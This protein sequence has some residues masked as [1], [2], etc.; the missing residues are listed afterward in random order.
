MYYFTKEEIAMKKRDAEAPVMLGYADVFAYIIVILV[1]FLLLFSGN[2]RTEPKK[3]L[4]SVGDTISEYSLSE[5]RTVE[6]ENSTV[7]LNVVI[8][9]GEVY[10]KSSTCHDAICIDTGRISK[11]GQIIVCAPAMTAI[12]IV[13][14]TED[15]Y[16]AIIR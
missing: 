3:V 9:N 8:E 4:I 6:I 11:T 2:G 16:D 1:A 10:V 14:E 15:G 5:N 13:G 12:R 7:K